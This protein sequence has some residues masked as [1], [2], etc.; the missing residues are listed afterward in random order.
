[1]IL[2]PGAT[3]QSVT[4]QI[5][6]DTGLAATGL[7]AATF[8]TT[9]YKIA[10]ASAAVSVSLSDLAA[11]TSS[12]SSGGV[13]EISGGYY[14]L[15][16]PNGALSSA[17]R[18]TLVGDA[19]GKHLIASPLDVQYVQADGRQ[20]LGTT[21]TEGAAGRLAGAVSTFGNVASPAFTAAAVNQTGDGYARIGSAGAGLT[22]LGDT[23]V[24]NLDAAVTSR[25]ASYTQPTGFLA[26]TFPGTVASPTNITAGTITTVTNLTNL[27]S[28]PANWL[29]AAGIAAGAI[30]AAKFATSVVDGDGQWVFPVFAATN[31]IAAGTIQAGALNGKGD[32]L[33]AVGDVTLAASQ[34]NYA[35]AVAGDA[36]ALSS[37]GKQ[38]VADA[39]N[40]P[41]GGLP[42]AGS[43]NG[44]LTAV[45]ALAGTVN[46]KLG[47]WAATGR[48]TVL[49]AFQA[50]FRKDTDATVPGNVNADLG[51][52]AGTA[53]NTA[54]SL[55]AIAELGGGG[56]GTT[57]NEEVTITETDVAIDD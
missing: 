35:P 21:M 53:D 29:T 37:T 23:R 41:P 28:I 27:P 36:M 46:A 52:G 7:V 34:P 47:G 26:A 44:I 54:D 6:D 1:M 42:Q 10:G 19:S 40:L 55:Q 30:T 25:M 18:V 16:V 39:L 49:G 33:T 43:V 11:I 31:S 14:R 9:T 24:A 8:P 48:N 50:M 5:V 4:I 15:D 57:V 12:Y 22:A 45:N 51:S 17:G 56:G 32:W 13:K 20:L 2:A 3:S 38:D